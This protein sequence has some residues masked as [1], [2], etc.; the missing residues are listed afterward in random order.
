MFVLL[1]L[2]PLASSLPSNLAYNSYR[3]RAHHASSPVSY[4]SKITYTGLALT[5]NLAR[6]SD[7]VEQTRT[8]ANSLKTTL[9][10]LATM[11]GA[12]KIVNRVI[13]DVNNVCLNSLEEAIEAVET[14]TRIVENAGPEIKQLIQ[15]VEAFEKITDTPTVIRES[16]KMLRL[17]EVL[18]PKLA[19]ANVQVCKANNDEAFGS[20]RSL[21]VLVDELSSS[22]QITGIETKEK[23]KTSAKII[24][25]A[26]TFITQLNKSFTKFDKLCSSDK[27]YNVEAITSIGDMM[28]G[29]ADLFGALG[30]ISDAEDIRKQEDFTKRVV[31]NIKK[32]GNYDLGTLECNKNGS[33]KVAAQTLDDIATL[34]EEVGLETLCTQL[35]VDLDCSFSG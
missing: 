21:A 20:L 3:P 6:T 26:T 19:P 22:N 25:G 32:L 2:V 1:L 5:K 9:R 33:F 14:G 23:L 4:K 15:T 10:S 18:M 16:A 7:F 8:Q 24:S 12:N 28:S 27:E 11:P 29:L 34:I 31:A 13:N 35:G 17:L 30:G